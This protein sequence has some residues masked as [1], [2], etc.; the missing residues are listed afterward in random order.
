MFLS[1]R[2]IIRFKIVIFFSISTI[3]FKIIPY[4]QKGKKMIDNLISQIANRF[5]MHSLA[6]VKIN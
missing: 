5:K 3:N 4:N 1:Q 6:N 2:L